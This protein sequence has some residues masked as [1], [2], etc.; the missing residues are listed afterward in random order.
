VLLL[1]FLAS[2]CFIGLKSWQQQNVTHEQY[3]L[4]PPTSMAMAFFE[5]YIIAKVA[6]QGHSWGL[7]VAIGAGAGIGSLVAT[8]LHRRMRDGRR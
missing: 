1:A 4:I 8:W 6:Q 3:W 5:V 7:V 2:L